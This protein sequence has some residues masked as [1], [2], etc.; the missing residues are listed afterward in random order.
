[1]SEDDD[2]F[3]TTDPLDIIPD[4]LSADR[5]FYD[6]VRLLDPITRNLVVQSHMQ[7]TSALIGLL[8]MRMVAPQTTRM[9]LNFPLTMDTSGNFFDPV[10]VLPNTQQI[11]AAIEHNVPLTDTQCSIC[12]EPVQLATRIRHCGHCFHPQ[13]IAQWFS[14]NPRC[15][16]CRY[17]IRDLHRYAVEHS[18]EDN[19]MHPDEES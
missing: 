15:P 8:R 6:I 11:V 10:P 3:H 13:C 2:T 1:M 19:R 5:S 14:M 9:I 7:N 12:Q 4:I 16:M 18:N 17:D